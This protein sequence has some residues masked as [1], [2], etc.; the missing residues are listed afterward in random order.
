MIDMEIN[1]FS[2]GISAEGRKWWQET[3]AY[4][5]KISEIKKN[6]RAKY[7]AKLKPEKNWISRLWIILQR[8]REINRRI[9]QLDSKRNLYLG[10]H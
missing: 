10:T 9:V 5:Q 3:E 6:V 4:Q 7:R 2:T 1:F 8:N